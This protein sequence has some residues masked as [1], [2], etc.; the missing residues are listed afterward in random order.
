MTRASTATDLV[1]SPVAAQQP[2]MPGVE[3]VGITS[4]RYQ[5]HQRILVEVET[6]TAAGT[7]AAAPTAEGQR[8]GGVAGRRAAPHALTDS[9]LWMKCGR[10]GV[11]W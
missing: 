9:C 11:N 5:A 7:R 2:P 10:V 6:G 8:Q 3:Q 1:G 4:A